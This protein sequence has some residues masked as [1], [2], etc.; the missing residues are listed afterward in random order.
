MFTSIHVVAAVITN[1]HGEV[2]I[3]LRPA[4]VHQGGLWEFPG[5][6]VGP[7]EDTYAA[8]Q[9]EIHEELG[10]TVQAAH[11]LIRIPHRY[12]DRYVLLDVWRVTAFS[13]TPHGREAQ[14]VRWA[15]PAGLDAACFPEA[16][17]PILAA[18]SLP[19]R[20]LITPEPGADFLARLERALANGIELV[21]LRAKSLDRRAYLELAQA[22]C[23]RA[24]A[25]GAQVLL[26]ADP[27]LVAEVGA[28]GVHLTTQR[29]LA[30]SRRPLPAPLWVAASCH[31]SA[32]LTH[33]VRIGCDFAVLGPV[34]PTQTHSDAPH[35]DWPGLRAL[36]EDATLPVYALGGLA[37]HDLESAW[38]A[39]AQ[40]IAAI[41][42]LWPE[43]P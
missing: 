43:E 17:K 32:E 29:L 2:L 38:R 35:L 3:S 36:T 14:P 16:N 31:S 33:A 24:Q 42:G 30:L 37:V 4:H 9:R 19:D 7:G 15:A 5:G 28:Q 1:P 13:G 12:P 34:R 27:A 11:P 8:L 10:I 18:A 6:K 41:R 22:V 40:G 26:N 39:G 23:A 21:Q 25:V 20:Y